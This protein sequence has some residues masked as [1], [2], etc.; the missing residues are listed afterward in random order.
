MCPHALL[1]FQVLAARLPRPLPQD[2]R[3]GVGTARTD[4]GHHHVPRARGCTIARE[5][6]Q[7]RKGAIIGGDGAG[8]HRRP[9]RWR[10]DMKIFFYCDDD[11]WWVGPLQLRSPK[12]RGVPAD[13]GPFRTYAETV[14][15]W[16]QH[17]GK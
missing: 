7:G 15:Y 9:D 2:R 8:A 3:Q 1:L 12:R 16:L 17:I 5:E 11:G 13:H 10:D 6:A 14:Q 4:P